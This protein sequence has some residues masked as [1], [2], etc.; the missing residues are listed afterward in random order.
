MSAG[1][2]DDIVNETELPERE[3][4]EAVEIELVPSMGEICVSGKA[5]MVVV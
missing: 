3:D 2:I 4:Q 1:G 5:V